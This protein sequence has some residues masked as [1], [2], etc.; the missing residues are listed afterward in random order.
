MEIRDKIRD[1]S[2]VR[3]CKFSIADRKD[4]RWEEL[5]GYGLKLRKNKR[6]HRAT[7][8]EEKKRKRK[9]KN[10]KFRERER[11]RERGESPPQRA[12]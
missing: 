7:E 1:T 8:T 5:S 11:G 12:P 9:R 10:K 6:L 3:R 4:D 2:G